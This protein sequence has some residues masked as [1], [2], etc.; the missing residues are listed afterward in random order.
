MALKT[1]G[2]PKI[3][4]RSTKVVSKGF[5]GEGAWWSWTKFSRELDHDRDHNKEQDGFHEMLGV[6]IVWWFFA[7]YEHFML[8]NW[9]NSAFVGFFTT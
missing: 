5:V 3:D 8:I 6:V 1:N 7:D 4:H 2:N 9:F